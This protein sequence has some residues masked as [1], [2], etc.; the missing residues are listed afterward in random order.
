[1]E[2]MRVVSLN[3]SFWIY[4]SLAYDDFDTAV[5]CKRNTICF[6]LCDCCSSLSGTRHKFILTEDGQTGWTSMNL[7]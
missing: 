3:K 7:P 6:V 2:M 5:L 4:E 1:M